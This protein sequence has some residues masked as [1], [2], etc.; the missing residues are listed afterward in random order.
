[1]KNETKIRSIGFGV[2]LVSMII[3]LALQLFGYVGTEIT[4][5]TILCGLAFS[6][7]MNQFAYSSAV[8]EIF[9]NAKTNLEQLEKDF[10]PDDLEMK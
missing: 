3:V 7:I 4:I 10:K 1:M 2:Q 5:P 8:N 9:D 6:L